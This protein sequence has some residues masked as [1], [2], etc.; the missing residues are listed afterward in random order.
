MPDP[1]KNFYPKNPI[2][3]KQIYLNE[4]LP[5]IENMIKNYAE[6]KNYITSTN[7]C[8]VQVL[9]LDPNDPKWCKQNNDTGKECWRSEQLEKP[10]H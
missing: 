7:K 3:N 9:C 5:A 4:R 2:N 10:C 6:E 1:K 8:V